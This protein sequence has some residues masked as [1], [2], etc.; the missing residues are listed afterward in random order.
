MSTYSKRKLYQR[1]QIRN[2]KSAKQHL[3][4]LRDCLRHVALKVYYY[5]L[6]ARYRQVL[7][8]RFHYA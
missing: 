5:L 6:I 3:K 2:S 4:K 1:S 8:T 7:N